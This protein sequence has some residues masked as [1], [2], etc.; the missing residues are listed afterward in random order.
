MSNETSNSK[1]ARPQLAFM[2][3]I[4]AA[5]YLHTDRLGVLKL[6]EEGR[7]KTFGGKASNPFVRTDEVLKLVETLDL[8][9]DDTLIDPK[10]I[11]RNDPVRKLKLRIQQDAKWHEVDEGGMRAW[12]K[13][14]DPVS[15]ER[16]RQVAR[17]AISQL[18]KIIQ[19]LDETEAERK[20]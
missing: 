8:V 6:I 7:L 1:P 18:Q 13:E 16:M 17:D 12:A 9:K 2:D 4:E 19:V 15:Y 5:A 20:K 3:T 14:L 10:V 11:H